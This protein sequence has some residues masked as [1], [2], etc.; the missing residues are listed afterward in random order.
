MLVKVRNLSDQDTPFTYLSNGEAVGAATL[1]VKNINGFSASWAIQVG[2][3]GEE[4]A[5]ILMIS[6]SAPSGTSLSITGTARFSHPTDTPVSAIK[7]DQLI[8]KRS[9]SGT[10]GTATAMT[11]GTVSIT[12]D[13][14]YTFFDDTSGAST[15]AYRAAFRNSVSGE[16]SSDSDWLTPDGFSF[17]S[18]ARM[19]ERMKRKLNSAGF[20]KDD[21]IIDDWT[22]EWLESMNNV[23]ID[24]N[25]DYAIGTVDIS[26]S[27]TSG[28]GTIT[29]SDF[30]EIRRVWMTS[31][32][33]TFY[34][35]RKMS[36]IDFEPD[37]VF[38]ET[39]PFYFYQGDNIIGRK[40]SDSS[41]TARIA[42]Y[43]MQPVMSNDT[44]ELP[45]SMRA[46]TK[47]FID[48]N[49]AQAYYM[50]NKPEMGDRFM[51]SANEGRERFRQEITPRTKSGPQ[52]ITITDT[53]DADDNWD[54]VV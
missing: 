15:Y 50:D 5:E 26:F 7:F 21:D 18:L 11:N 4:Q 8:F 30:K 25:K 44:D 14:E 28:L 54:L 17:Y 27:G 16:V 12:P 9:T 13:L 19:R 32:G 24:V 41:G 20:I 2:K 1:R 38:S 23:A 3:T 42:Y 35:A 51:A 22:N 36:L 40:P 43:K 10:A 34:S 46:Y 48:H 45:V 29:A 39:R 52:S 33:S 37:E 6:A 53:I 47:S 31:D 49:L